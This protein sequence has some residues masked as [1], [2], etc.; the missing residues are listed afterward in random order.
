MFKKWHEYHKYCKC[1]AQGNTKET[2]CEFCKKYSKL[3]FYTSLFK[4]DKIQ[5]KS[6]MHTT[7]VT[8]EIW[9]RD[10]TGK[11]FESPGRGKKPNFKSKQQEQKEEIQQ[12]MNDYAKTII[13]PDTFEFANNKITIKDS[14]DVKSIVIDLSTREIWITTGENCKYKF[15]GHS[16]KDLYKTSNK[17]QA[18]KDILKEE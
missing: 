16:V 4:R 10:T 17:L 11:V 12:Q 13:I 6:G 1:I 9:F 2:M 5:F 3:R 18:I 7:L 15:D 8:L 14:R